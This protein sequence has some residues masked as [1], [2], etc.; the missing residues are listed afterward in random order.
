MSRQHYAGIVFFFIKNGFKRFLLGEEYSA[1]ER[2]YLS[3]AGKDKLSYA[4]LCSI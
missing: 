1:V 3:S 2:L 4:S